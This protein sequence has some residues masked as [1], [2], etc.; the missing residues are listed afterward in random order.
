MKRKFLSVISLLFISKSITA[1][2]VKLTP[3]NG[4]EYISDWKVEL[5]AD[6]KPN[7]SDKLFEWL[8]GFRLE[9]PEGIFCNKGY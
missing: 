6:G 4:K 2:Q 3:E 1:Q 7:V 8:K 9:L 5:F